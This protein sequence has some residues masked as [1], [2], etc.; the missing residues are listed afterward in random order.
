MGG[1]GFPVIALHS[2]RGG[3]SLIHFCLSHR[4]QE[5]GISF[6]KNRVLPKHLP[7]SL[8]SSGPVHILSPASIISEPDCEDLDAVR[9]TRMPPHPHTLIPLLFGGRG[10]RA[11]TRTLRIWRQVQGNFFFVVEQI[12]GFSSRKEGVL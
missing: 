9:P 12:R 6:W 7:A 10:K 11:L 1:L 3:Q 5:G 2:L 4:L 8:L